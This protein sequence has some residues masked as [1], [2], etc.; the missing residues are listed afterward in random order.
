MTLKKLIRQKGYTQQS[1]ADLLGVGQSAVSNWCNGY[2]K[3]T[4]SNMV[5]VS[6]ALG[7]S[8]DAIVSALSEEGEQSNE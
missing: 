8:V 3:M 6:G 4:Y 2:G 1:L 5:K 7:V